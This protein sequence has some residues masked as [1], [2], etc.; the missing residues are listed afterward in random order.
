MQIAWG[1]YAFDRHYLRVEVKRRRKLAERSEVPLLPA[2]PV[3]FALAVCQLLSH[4]AVSP[5]GVPMCAFSAVMTEAE[6]EVNRQSAR[7]APLIFIKTRRM[8]TAV[9]GEILPKQSIEFLLMT[10][11]TDGAK[12]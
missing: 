3:A 10:S 4:R 7:A 9:T 1:L 6:D 5:N 8:D 2:A 11:Q 12:L